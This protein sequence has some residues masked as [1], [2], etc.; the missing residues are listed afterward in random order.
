MEGFVLA[1]NF[2][3]NALVYLEIA[4]SLSVFYR[5]I[6]GQLIYHETLPQSAYIVSLP[7]GR[8]DVRIVNIYLIRLLHPAY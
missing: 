4:L 3:N 2:Q 7:Y 8:Q 5:M 1:S 6:H